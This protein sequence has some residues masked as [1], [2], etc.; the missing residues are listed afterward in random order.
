MEIFQFFPKNQND[1]RGV[2]CLE[3]I[4]MSSR[5]SN[6]PKK[7]GFQNSVFVFVFS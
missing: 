1:K 5:I 7:N 4:E 6:F 3:S 2:N